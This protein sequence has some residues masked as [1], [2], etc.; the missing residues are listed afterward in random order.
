MRPHRRVPHSGLGTP[1]AG[2]GG[3]EQH[4]QCCSTAGFPLT[5]CALVFY[6]FPGFY[7]FPKWG[8]RWALLHTGFRCA[9]WWLDICTVDGGAPTGSHPPGTAHRPCGSTSTSGSPTLGSP[10]RTALRPPVRAAPRP[11]PSHRPPAPPRTHRPALRV[12]ESVSVSF[13]HCALQAPPISEVWKRPKCPSVDT[14]LKSCGAFTHWT[15]SGHTK[16]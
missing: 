1:P 14:G 5:P 15:P 3:L 8:W 12:C 6:G 4:R 16:E 9:A 10:P 7:F 2:V 13:G 11:R